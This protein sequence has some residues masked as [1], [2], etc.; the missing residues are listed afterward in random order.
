MS[1]NSFGGSCP[2][3]G[4]SMDCYEDWK[5]H[6]YVSG[7]CLECG[8]SYY[9]QDSQMTLEE[10]NIQREDMDLPPLQKLKEQKKEGE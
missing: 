8:F 10:V 2:K 1:G 4:G 9:T 7:E 5:P 3:C 6:A